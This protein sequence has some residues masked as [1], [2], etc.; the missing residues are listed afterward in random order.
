V[1]VAL[2]FFS[3]GGVV[4]EGGDMFFHARAR[5]EAGGPLGLAFHVG[6]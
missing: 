5:R 2:D 1:G 4:L 6:Q 3:D